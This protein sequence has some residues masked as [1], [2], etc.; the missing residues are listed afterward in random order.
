MAGQQ[1]LIIKLV[2]LMIFL[3]GLGVAGYFG[4]KEYEKRCPKGLMVC[5]G[6]EDEPD[7][8]PGTPDVD[9]SDSDP[10]GPSDTTTSN[11]YTKSE[12]YNKCARFLVADD[13]RTCL[14][15]KMV[16]VRWSWS[17]A[18]Q[19]TELAACKA[20]TEKWK[21]IIS[22]SGYNNH[23]TKREYTYTTKEA[24]SVIIDFG[25]KAPYYLKSQNIKF[26]IIPLNNKD[27]QITPDLTIT[28]DSSNANTTNCDDVGGVPI[29]WEETKYVAP[30][31]K[32][33][34]PV[35]CAG[36]WKTGTVCKN[37]R[38]STTCGDPCDVTDVYI[39]TQQP[40]ST[41]TRCP[42]PLTRTTS[43]FLGPSDGC[44]PAPAGTPAPSP[45]RPSDHRDLVTD[46]KAIERA[47]DSKPELAVHKTVGDSLFPILDEG[48]SFK[49]QRACTRDLKEKSSD[50]PGFYV[51][52]RYLQDLNFEANQ[53]TCELP[54]DIYEVSACNVDVKPQH[55]V[56]DWSD[57]P[58]TL[59]AW[60]GKSCFM[61]EDATKRRKLL[62]KDQEYLISTPAGEV[63]TACPH[64]QGEK[65]TVRG[66]SESVVKDGCGGGGIGAC[67]QNIVSRNQC[68]TVFPAPQ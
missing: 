65:R 41:G 60:D 57:M 39:I 66:G 19:N 12:L 33:L 54:E 20:A 45:C 31:V 15:D 1:E 47:I 37:L 26:K 63:G 61:S 55:C 43:R 11:T 34:E 27:E 8:G 30:E 2:I 14:T 49:N 9:P 10:S 23:G 48:N 24:N 68:P 52:S 25:D 51:T 16:G 59:R 58:G 67:P 22:S 17:T 5:L 29:K 50:L 62:I 40:Q 53:R 64:K 13:T 7:N 35:N 3:V 36:Y 21:I 18:T 56:G 46:L 28:V 44:T 32:P 4:Y 38:G 6:L 42:S